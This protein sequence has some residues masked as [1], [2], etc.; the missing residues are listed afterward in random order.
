VACDCPPEG[1]AQVTIGAPMSVTAK[2]V[3]VFAVDK[4]IDALQTRLRVAEKVL[5]EQTKLAGD[6]ES[7]RAK[8]E[9]EIKTLQAQAANFEGESKRLEDKI[10]KLKEQMNTAQTNKQFQAF[11]VEVNTLGNEKGAAEKSALELMEKMDVLRKQADE[12]GAQRSERESMAVVAKT[13]RDGREAEIKDK[14]EALKAERAT[15]AAEVPADVLRDYERVFQQ[16]GEDSV[17][18]VELQS[19]KDQEF[20]CGACM[21]LIPVQTVNGILA[22]GKVTTCTNCRCYLFVSDELKQQLAEPNKPRTRK[23]KS[24]AEAL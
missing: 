20:T 4:Q 18:Q 24:E 22:S 11:L 5:A 17:A 6:F 9:S 2:L 8:V 19:R 14:L 21:M 10:N 23:S 15:L 12:L 16:R 13:N 1:G 7:K 3:K